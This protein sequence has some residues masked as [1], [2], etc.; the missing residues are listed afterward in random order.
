M[1]TFRATGVDAADIP[2]QES[3]PGEPGVIVRV[4]PQGPIGPEGPQGLR[5][6]L[7]ADG[8]TGSQGVA[9]AAGAAGPQGIQGIQGDTGPGQPWQILDPASVLTVAESLAAAVSGDFYFLP[10]GTYE[11]GEF[12][13]MANGVRVV[14][15]PQAV[16]EVGPTDYMTITHANW[17]ISGVTFHFTGGLHSLATYF[18]IGNAKN[19]FDECEFTAEDGTSGPK[20]VFTFVSGATACRVTNCRF[21]FVNPS[22]S[23]VCVFIDFGSTGTTYDIIVTGNAFWTR[24]NSTYDTTIFSQT[25]ASTDDHSYG[26]VIAH[27]Y[28]VAGGPRITVLVPFTGVSC[29]NNT[30]DCDGITATSATKFVDF[31]NSA[32]SDVRIEGNQSYKSIHFVTGIM[33]SW[34]TVAVVGNTVTG[35]DSSNLTALVNVTAGAESNNVTITGNS[36]HDVASGV[37]ISALT[38]IVRALTISGNTFVGTAAIG[39]FGVELSKGTGEIYVSVSGNTMFRFQNAIY[40]NYSSDADNTASVVGNQCFYFSDKGVYLSGYVRTSS[41]SGNTLV[42]NG[43]GHGFD[44]NGVKTSSFI[45]NI[46]DN[47]TTAQGI[48]YNSGGAEECS[49]IGNM[50]GPNLATLIDNFSGLREQNLWWSNGGEGPAQYARAKHADEQ[51]A[52]A[53]WVSDATLRFYVRSGEVWSFE[54]YA[55]VD[56]TGAATG[57]LFS[58]TGPTVTDLRYRTEYWEADTLYAAGVK[59]AWD[60]GVGFTASFTENAVVKI[61]GTVTPSA[62]GVVAFR[63]RQAARASDNIVVKRGSYVTAKQAFSG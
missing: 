26:A 58:L 55:F 53:S 61:S 54:F 2:S 13:S 41:F 33:N 59:T 21:Y 34:N 46:I 12:D 11:L 19:V 8:V 49:F 32:I 4:G 51:F 28:I 6:P 62:D 10:A 50:A 15:S 30:F 17:N 14:G 56:M 31:P 3:V 29:M 44:C 63:S 5:G 20:N 22:A 24:D 27:N 42:G 23:H 40:L 16:I 35:L 1:A 48:Y 60:S 36:A 25:Y 57:E 38:Y 47:V 7:G 45:G 52:T 37:R 43:T 9:G 39:G 18:S